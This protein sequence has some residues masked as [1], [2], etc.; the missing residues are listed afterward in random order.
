MGTWAV[1]VAM[2]QLYIVE[3]P[4]PASSQAEF[5]IAI[6]SSQ[7]SRCVNVSTWRGRPASVRTPESPRTTD[8]ACRVDPFFQNIPVSGTRKDSCGYTRALYLPH[9][10]TVT[11]NINSIAI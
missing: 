4:M 10:E 1:H 3:L 5:S 6:A 9:E 11:V 2:R 8:G 7:S